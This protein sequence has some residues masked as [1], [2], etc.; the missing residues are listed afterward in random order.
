MEALAA[1]VTQIDATLE[2]AARSTLGRMQDDL[3]KLQ[4]R[5][6]RPPSG[7]TRRCA[8]SSSTRRRRRFPAAHPQEREIGFV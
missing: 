2:G 8:G 7:R 1:A 6:S 5:S 4:A 3:K